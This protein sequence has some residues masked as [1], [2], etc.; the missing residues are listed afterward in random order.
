MCYLCSYL[1]FGDAT[2]ADILNNMDPANPL[3]AIAQIGILTTVMLSFPL[4]LW[5]L[6]QCI[7]I[8]MGPR[9]KDTKWK[10]LLLTIGIVTGSLILAIIVPNIQV[11]FFICWEYIKLCDMFDITVGIL[12]SSYERWAR[13]LIF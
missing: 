1:H 4:N 2:D 9:R 8:V 13:Q 3:I 11:V 12:Y 5:P 7:L 10:F 6:R